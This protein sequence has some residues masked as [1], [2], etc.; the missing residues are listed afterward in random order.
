MRQTAPRR[1]LATPGRPLTRGIAGVSVAALLAALGIFGLSHAPEA[2]AQQATVSITDVR[3]SDADDR[4]SD[5]DLA[6][7]ADVKSRQAVLDETGREV[8][9]ESARLAALGKFYY[10]TI[11]DIGSP[12][13][14]RMHPILH[15]MKLH[16]GVDI[17]APCDAPIWAVLPG[18]VVNVGS[19]GDSGN[20]VKIDHATVGGKHLVTAYLHMNSIWV[21]NGQVVTRGQQLGLSGS[22][23]L[24]TSCHLH[25]ALW[26]DGEN[27]DPVPYIKA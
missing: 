20:W 18:T 9:A 23:G 17:G 24:S 4:I 12:W 19:G 13:G 5:A 8:T 6:L 2:S 11:G 1:A 7:A 15:V 22:T 3:I 21:T 16:E 27:V 14:M 26:V 10:P 25:L